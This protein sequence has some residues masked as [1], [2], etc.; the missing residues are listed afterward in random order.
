MVD[1]YSLDQRKA[2]FPVCRKGEKLAAERQHKRLGKRWARPRRDG[3][4]TGCWL[5]LPVASTWRP[6]TGVMDRTAETYGPAKCKAPSAA[7]S[8]ALHAICKTPLRHRGLLEVQYEI[9]TE[10]SV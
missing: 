6:R 5:T 4:S 9:K 3:R 1:N 7:F 2:S 8:L 10:L